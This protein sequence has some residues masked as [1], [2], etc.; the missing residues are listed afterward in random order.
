MLRDGR[1]DLSHIK[2]GQSKRSVS[3]R[4]ISFVALKGLTKCKRK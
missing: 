3:G 1:A 4:L 2:V